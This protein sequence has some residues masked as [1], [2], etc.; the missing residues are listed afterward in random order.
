MRNDRGITLRRVRLP[1][2][3]DLGLL[4]RFRLPA[5]GIFDKNCKASQ[6]SAAAFA[7]ALAT[8][9]ETD[10]CAPNKG[11]IPLRSAFVLLGPAD[12]LP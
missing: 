11:C 12:R 9:P 5:V 3:P 7:K 1:E 6:P 8:P 10:T 2:A 4:E